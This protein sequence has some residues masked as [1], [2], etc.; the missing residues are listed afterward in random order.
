M[1]PGLSAGAMLGASKFSQ[2]GAPNN[3]FNI[4]FG[5]KA[6]YDYPVSSTYPVTVGA[7]LTVNWV[8]PGDTMLTVFTPF[9]TAKWWF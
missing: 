3:G 9:L 7:D 1:I 4:T 8:K 2:S 6:A 5:L